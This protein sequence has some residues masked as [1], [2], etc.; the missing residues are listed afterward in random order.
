MIGLPVQAETDLRL[1]V[2]YEPLVGCLKLFEC[3]HLV[4]A[5]G[6]FE[7]LRLGKW[8][9][10]H[11]SLSVREGLSHEGSTLLEAPGL[12][13]AGNLLEGI[14]LR[15]GVNPLE[16]GVLSERFAGEGGIGR[17]RISRLPGFLGG[18]LLPGRKAKLLII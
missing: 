3:R 17:F 7:G 9:S 8:L 14:Y 10:L 6:F 4:E 16:A 13:E 18:R 1:S 11:E 15:K 12:L 5:V 2:S